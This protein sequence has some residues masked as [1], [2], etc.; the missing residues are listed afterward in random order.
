MRRKTTQRYCYYHNIPHVVHLSYWTYCGTTISEIVKPLKQTTI[1]KKE[2]TFSCSIL[3]T[4]CTVHF[5]SKYL[6][7]VTQLN[8]KSFH[9]K[10]KNCVTVNGLAR[11]T[12]IKVLLC[13]ESPPH[14]LLPNLADGFNYYNQCIINVQFH[15]EAKYKL[16]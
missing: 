7:C 13:S 5:A 11:N 15:A 8:I 12:G 1:F 16:Q 9:W 14:W 10:K 2:L 6:F 4:F 3:H